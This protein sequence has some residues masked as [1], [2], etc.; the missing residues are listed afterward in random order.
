[1]VF[2]MKCTVLFQVRAEFLNNLLPDHVCVSVHVS[3]CL[4]SKAAGL[5][6]IKFGT[7]VIPMDSTLGSSSSQPTFTKGA[8][9]FKNLC[10]PPPPPFKCFQL[11]Y[12]RTKILK[13]GFVPEPVQ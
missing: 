3:A 11:F 10:L 5:I 6:W 12:N 8:L 2:V 13:T 1:M 9:I 4:N 7:D